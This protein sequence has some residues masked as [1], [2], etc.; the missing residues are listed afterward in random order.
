MSNIEILD[1]ANI[2][3]GQQPPVPNS[4]SAL[5]IEALRFANR[6]SRLLGDID[7]NVL[8]RIESDHDHSFDDLHD[9]IIRRFSDCSGIHLFIAANNLRL[10]LP[11][12]L[13]DD[14]DM[15]ERS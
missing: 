12:D 13:R 4:E 9:L 1:P 10:D 3:P 14:D 5:V 6:V 8:A 11:A 2:Q 15:D 7:R